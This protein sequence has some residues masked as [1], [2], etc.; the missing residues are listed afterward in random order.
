MSAYLAAAFEV[1]K[2]HPEGLN[3]QEIWEKITARELLTTEN[4]TLGSLRGILEREVGGGS[5]SFQRISPG[6]YVVKGTV[7]RP[8]RGWKDKYGPRQPSARLPHE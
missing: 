5:A 7:Y 1:L 2:E 6:R 3:V 4:P 8:R